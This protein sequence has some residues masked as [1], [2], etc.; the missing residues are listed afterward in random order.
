V[1]ELHDCAIDYKD[2]TIL[3]EHGIKVGEMEFEVQKTNVG[4]NKR[5]PIKKEL[6]SVKNEIDK[7]NK[8]I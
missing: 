1:Q 6:S 8:S 7:V 2:E 5:I 4:E 3:N